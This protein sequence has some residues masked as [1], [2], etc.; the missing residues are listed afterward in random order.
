MDIRTTGKGLDV[1]R[2]LDAHVRRRINFALGRFSRRVKRVHV[3]LADENGPDGG[4]DKTCRIAVR[5]LRLPAVIV[6]QTS[7]DLL[8]SVEVAA[9]RA[10][11]TVAGRISLALTSSS[12]GDRGV[13][14]KEKP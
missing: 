7:T 4:M 8:T 13:I 2:V 1:G 11:G 12:A 6:E 14:G 3:R 9:D 5:L 10:G